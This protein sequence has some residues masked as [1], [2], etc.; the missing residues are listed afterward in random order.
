M[1]SFANAFC[2]HCNLSHSVSSA[3][4]RHKYP[5]TI[6][7]TYLLKQAVDGTQCNQG[8]L[9]RQ[10]YTF[11]NLIITTKGNNEVIYYVSPADMWKT[12]DIWLYL[13]DKHNKIHNNFNYILCPPELLAPSMKM[14][15]EQNQLQRK[16]Y[17]VLSNVFFSLFF[18]KTQ[19]H[20][21]LQFNS[22][23]RLLS[24]FSSSAHSPHVCLGSSEVFGF[25]LHPKTCY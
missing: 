13:M 2:I 23:L 10:N 12:A 21:G 25:H 6:A 20:N 17:F 24:T 16:W 14:S 4:T 9:W 1:P 3:V 22:E 8:R 7:T 18:Y 15:K 5:P 11:I 19:W